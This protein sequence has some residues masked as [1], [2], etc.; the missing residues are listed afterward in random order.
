MSYT[1]HISMRVAGEIL[2][3]VDEQAK[4]MRW[5]RNATLNTCIEFGLLD[6]EKERG[7]DNPRNRTAAAAG[8]VEEMSSGD[9]NK[10]AEKIAGKMVAAQKNRNTR[11]PAPIFPLPVARPENSAEDK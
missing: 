2:L 3:L 1:K 4:R 5:S 8:R 10:V 6:L 11:P 9:V 7:V